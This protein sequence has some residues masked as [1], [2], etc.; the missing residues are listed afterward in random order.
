MIPV[1]KA[2]AQPFRPASQPRAVFRI[3][4]QTSGRWRV[5][6]AD[7]M[8]GGTFFERDAAIR[9]ARRESVGMPILVFQ[10]EPEQRR[11]VIEPFRGATPRS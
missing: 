11:A 5:S 2:A 9:F 4:Q 10:I 8:T 6:S 3:E 1:S 7:G